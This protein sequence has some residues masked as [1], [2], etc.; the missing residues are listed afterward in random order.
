MIVAFLLFRIA[1]STAH[2]SAGCLDI[3]LSLRSIVSCSTLF[4]EGMEHDARL[5]F[6]GKIKRGSRNYES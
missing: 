5:V 3:K 2:G 1:N 6:V 4:S